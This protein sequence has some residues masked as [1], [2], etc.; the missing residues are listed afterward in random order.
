MPGIKLSTS[1]WKVE[2]QTDWAID[3]LKLHLPGTAL[4]QYE[5]PESQPD[6]AGMK[7]KVDPPTPVTIG[8]V[9]N[10]LPIALFIVIFTREIAITQ[11]NFSTWTPLMPGIE[12][13]T[14]EWKVQQQ[15]DWAIDLLKLHQHQGPLQAVRNA[16]R[17]AQV[18]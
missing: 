17:P 9:F 10:Q 3:G 1:E 5:M 12:L 14:S 11:R 2:Q 18:E 16:W 4:K 15:N 13:V 8:N 7:V 6:T